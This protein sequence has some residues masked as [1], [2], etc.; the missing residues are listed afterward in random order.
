MLSSGLDMTVYTMAGNHI[1]HGSSIC[2]MSQSPGYGASFVDCI[3]A[4]AT[5]HM[6]CHEC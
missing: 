6:S 3:R 4:W 2:A 1:H 5:G